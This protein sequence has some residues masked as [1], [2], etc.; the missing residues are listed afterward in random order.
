MVFYEVVGFGLLD[1]TKVD[2]MLGAIYTPDEL[3]HS[4]GSLTFL[5]L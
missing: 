4:S 5:T 3:Y 1:S 2:V